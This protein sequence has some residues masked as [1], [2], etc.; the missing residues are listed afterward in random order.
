[1]SR[2]SFLT[3][4]HGTLTLQ[5]QG[6]LS[7]AAGQF[8]DNLTVVGGTGRFAGATG[9][10]SDQGTF[11]GARAVHRVGCDLRV[12]GQSAGSSG[13]SLTL[14]GHGSRIPNGLSN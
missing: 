10:L 12:N 8:T 1:L 9:Q 4:D 3:T 11:L 6:S 5:D 14:S 13:R 2:L 7:F